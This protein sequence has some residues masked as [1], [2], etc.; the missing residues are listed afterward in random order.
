MTVKWEPYWYELDQSVVVGDIDLFYLS[1][2]GL[3]LMNGAVRKDDRE[4]G[5]RIER[6]THPEL[7]EVRGIITIGL[8]YTIYLSDGT[9][10]LVDAEESPGKL[11]DPPSAV[12]E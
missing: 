8:D 9:A 11:Y 4:V 6:I 2:D 7:G 12:K 3:S 5:A 10:L 1:K